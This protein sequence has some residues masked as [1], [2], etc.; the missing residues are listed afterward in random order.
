MDVR[1]VTL[2]EGGWIVSFSRVH[3]RLLHEDA[4]HFSRHSAFDGKRSACFFRFLIP[5]SCSAQ[6]GDCGLRMS[7]YSVSGLGIP[8][9]A[10]KDTFH[11][12]LSTLRPIHYPPWNRTDVKVRLYHPPISDVMLV[13]NACSRLRTRSPKTVVWSRLP[14]TRTQPSSPSSTPSSTTVLKCSTRTGSGSQYRAGR[15]R[16]SWISVRLWR[17]LVLSLFLD[18]NTGTSIY[19]LTTLLVQFI[20]Y[21]TNDVIKFQ[22]TRSHEWWM[23]AS[24]RLDIVLW[25]SI[26]RGTPF[27]SSS[28]RDFTLTSEWTGSQS[29]PVRILVF[30]HIIIQWYYR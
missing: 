14:I 30:K 27:R 8:A 24:S 5:I 13:L 20:F 15:M 29:F 6:Q 12:P 23:V 16:L 11:L 22:V 19:Q 2:S 28:N 3:N 25:T 1:A 7:F 17:H 10:F 4:Q 9:D 18:F 21:F 26:A